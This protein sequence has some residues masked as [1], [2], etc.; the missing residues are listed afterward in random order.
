MT[1]SSSDTI[2]GDSSHFIMLYTDVGYAYVQWFVKGADGKEK[3]VRTNTGTGLGTFDYLSGYDYA[4]LGSTTGNKVTVKAVAYR[5]PSNQ[6]DHDE[7]TVEITVWKPIRIW[8]LSAPS[9]CVEGENVA[10]KAHTNIPAS[11][12]EFSIDNGAWQPVKDGGES[13][14][15]SHVF[16]DDQ[17]SR[18]GVIHTIKAVAYATA[19]GKEISSEPAADKIAVYADLGLLWYIT[20]VHIDSITG[21]AA[22][23]R[24]RLQT[25]HWVYYYNDGGDPLAKLR[26]RAAWYRKRNAPGWQQWGTFA[27][28]KEQ[29]ERIFP[30]KSAYAVFTFSKQQDATLI[31]DHY[32][33]VQGYTNL[34]GR[35]DNKLGI[36]GA[37]VEHPDSDHLTGPLYPIP[38]SSPGAKA[39]YAPTRSD[40]IPK[41]R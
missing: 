35:W 4:G 33:A 13:T 5:N 30:Q 32:H 6:D 8:W 15:Y 11:R 25:T 24:Y 2:A 14:Q 23:D 38:P 17:G 27:G 1:P 16:G 21:L 12:V 34:I 19:A 29:D 36:N 20:A 31:M 26:G 9:K 40:G 37:R 3:L 41:P 10:I 18:D 7:E 39:N 28:R 22:R